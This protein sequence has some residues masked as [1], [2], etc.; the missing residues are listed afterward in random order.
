MEEAEIGKVLH[1][2]ERA[3]EDEG[4]VITGRS[5]R[6]Y[7][8]LGV[9]IVSVAA[10]P[11]DWPHSASMFEAVARIDLSG[12]AGPVRVHCSATDDDPILNVWEAV[13]LLD[14]VPLPEFPKAVRLILDERNVVSRMIAVNLRPPFK[15]LRWRWLG[16]PRADTPA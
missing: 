16:D 9:R 14:Y 8:D 5:N 13:N 7:R 12:N 15:G 4:L 6:I 3:C 1:T 11:R 2:I 10:S